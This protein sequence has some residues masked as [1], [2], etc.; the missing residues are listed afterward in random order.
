MSFFQSLGPEVLETVN[1]EIVT[2]LSEIAPSQNA[3]LLDVGCWDGLWS[4]EAERT[5]NFYDSSG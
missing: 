3:R 5:S 4:F 2:F 1:D